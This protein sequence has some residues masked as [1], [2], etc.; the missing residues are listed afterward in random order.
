MRIS[1]ELE[2]I[3]AIIPLRSYASRVIIEGSFIKNN[4]FQFIFIQIEIPFVLRLL[5][6]F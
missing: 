1:R 4:S 5:S 2:T 3:K 6:L